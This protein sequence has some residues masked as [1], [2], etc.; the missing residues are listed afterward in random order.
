VSVAIESIEPGVQRLRCRSWRGAAVG[1]DVS[2]YLLD[3]VLVDTGFSR[4]AGAVSR[5]VRG[6]APRGCVVTHS[7]ED[8][9]GNAAVLAATGLPLRMHAGCEAV[10]RAPPRIELY[11]RLVWGRPHALQA[12]LADFSL[13]D[14]E[15]LELPGHTPDHI[16]VWDPVRR[17]LASGDLFLGVKVRVAHHDE[18]PRML[19]ASLRAAAALEPRL[20]LDAHRGPLTDAA[21]LLH[22]KAV[23][24]LGERGR[25]VG[26]I[27][28]R[29]L[30]RE[31][32]V[33]LVSLGE[34]SKHELV[35]V[36]LRDG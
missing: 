28:R 25:D 19:I 14:L 18:S 8:H 34:Y 1:Y 17:I 13:G 33:G 24:S 15:L 21:R 10:L 6:L 26:E 27:S 30:G 5:A 3:G 35:R 36:L 29:V 9:S 20:L 7:H 4:A 16:V 2:A 31:P 12:P 32:F 22:A 11:R 23:R